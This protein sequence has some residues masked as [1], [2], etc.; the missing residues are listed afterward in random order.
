MMISSKTDRPR[1]L[2][3]PSRQAGVAAVE[4]GIVIVVLLLIIAGT[5]GFGRTFWYLDAL[6]K[7][8]RDGS[9]LL[10]TW[11]V[12]DISAGV[13]A[14]RDITV[15]NAN[16]ANLSPPLATGNV[17]AECLNDSFA[18]VACSNGTAPGNVRVRITGFS[19]SLGEWFPFIGSGGSID[20]GVVGLSPH[21]TMPYM[22]Y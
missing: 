2:T 12:S 17:V 19:V 7:A 21:T 9:R 11:E 13:T 20:Y 16:A 22:N 4:M 3:K 18:V 1:P 14:A 5:I 8:T 15:S 6:T 10:S